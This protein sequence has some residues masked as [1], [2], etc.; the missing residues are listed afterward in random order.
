MK[1]NTGIDSKNS[2][3]KD[4]DQII[5]TDFQLNDNILWHIFYISCFW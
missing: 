5:S 2:A 4:I 3:I 1:W